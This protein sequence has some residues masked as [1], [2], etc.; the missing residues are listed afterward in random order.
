[1]DSE[2]PVPP[3]DPTSEPAP[4]ADLREQF[5][6]RSGRG[7]RQAERAFIENKLEMIRTD[8]SLSEEERAAAIAEAKKKLNRPN[9]PPDPLR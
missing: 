8:P 1:M 7:D 5:A 3:R 6:R 2:P 9:D 4:I